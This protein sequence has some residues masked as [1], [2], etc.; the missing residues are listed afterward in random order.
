MS[1]LFCRD[2]QSTTITSEN[3]CKRRTQREPLKQKAPLATGLS[4]VR[5]GRYSAPRPG[6]SLSRSSLHSPTIRLRRSRISLLTW[7][8]G[9]FGGLLKIGG[10]SLYLELPLLD[11]GVGL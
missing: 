7:R 4:S 6:R 3:Q 2:R 5:M 11:V 9:I 1:F 8:F 10:Q